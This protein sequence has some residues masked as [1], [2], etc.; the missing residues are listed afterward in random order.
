MSAELALAVDVRLARR[1]PPYPS[2][3]LQEA[4]PVWTC[5]D[6]LAAALAAASAG[7][8]SGAARISRCASGSSSMSTAP[9]LA[10]MYAKMS[11][12]CCSPRPL[13]ERSSV[14]SFSRDCNL[15]TLSD[16]APKPRQ[17]S[18]ALL[19]PLFGMLFVDAETK[20]KTSAVD[21]HAR[22]PWCLGCACN[23]QFFSPACRL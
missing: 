8:R 19:A 23:L 15:A 18:W 16:K 22:A 13:E 6:D 3:Q 7:D 11:I 1:R 17:T 4:L 20:R 2:R 21:L 14:T 9:G 5:R 12:V 10:Y